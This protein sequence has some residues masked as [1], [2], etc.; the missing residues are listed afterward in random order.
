MSPKVK[1]GAVLLHPK[2]GV[3]ARQSFCP[4]CMKDGDMVMLG[5]REYAGLCLNCKMLHFGIR[6]DKDSVCCSCGHSGF[7]TM[8]IPDNAKIPVLCEECEALME[9]THKML[10]EG[11]CLWRCEECG[12][13]GVFGHLHPVAIDMRKNHPDAQGAIVTKESCPICAQGGLN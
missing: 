7:N 5:V 4:R 9:T 13:T 12:H 8:P 11:G 10:S 1:P 6:D 2:K 3:N